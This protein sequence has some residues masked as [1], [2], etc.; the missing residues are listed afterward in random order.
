VGAEGYYRKH[1]SGR[2]FTV[3]EECVTM[4]RPDLS[5]Y[6]PYIELLADKLNEDAIYKMSKTDAIKIAVE[7]ALEKVVPDVVVN[8]K[9]KKYI[10]LDF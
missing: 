3:A 10:K 8:K 9:R 2:I 1:K 7:K 6:L 5:D 4:Y